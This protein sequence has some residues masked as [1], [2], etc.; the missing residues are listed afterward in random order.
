LA[1]THLFIKIEIEHDDDETPQKLGA[2]ICRRIMKIYGVRLAEVSNV[3]AAE[4]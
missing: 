2:E 3:T 4:E 1:V